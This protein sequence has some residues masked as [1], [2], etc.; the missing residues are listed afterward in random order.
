VVTA[1]PKGHT[2]RL[3]PVPTPGLRLLTE[4]CQTF[5]Y[6]LEN[7]ASEYAY[8]APHLFMGPTERYHASYLHFLDILR[9]PSD[10]ASTWSVF[11]SIMKVRFIHC[12]RMVTPAL[13]LHDLFTPTMTNM[14]W[15]HYLPFGFLSDPKVP[16]KTWRHGAQRQQ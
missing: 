6:G 16:T 7:A 12:L 1:T 9:P 2:V 11:G 8:R 13:D 10:N 15:I 3:R 4:D 14:I 5:P